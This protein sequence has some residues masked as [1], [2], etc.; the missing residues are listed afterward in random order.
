VS[1]S[2]GEL[3]RN[4]GFTEAMTMGGGTMIGAGIFIFPGTAV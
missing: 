4:L 1:D 3:A 2:E